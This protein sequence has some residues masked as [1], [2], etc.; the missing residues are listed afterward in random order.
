MKKSTLIKVFFGITLGILA[1]TTAIKVFPIIKQ[2]VDNFL[3]KDNMDD[4]DFEN[5]LED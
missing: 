3:D 1:T 5:D 4:W 2:K